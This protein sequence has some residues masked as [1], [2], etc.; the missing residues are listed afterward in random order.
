MRLSILCS[1]YDRDSKGYLGFLGS[2]FCNG[3]NVVEGFFLVF[4]GMGGII[5]YY[6]A[7]HREEF[8]ITLGPEAVFR[9]YE[10]LVQ[11]LFV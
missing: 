8:E 4:D 6:A 7:A 5:L 1:L 3:Y 11:F 10:A 9:G 2:F